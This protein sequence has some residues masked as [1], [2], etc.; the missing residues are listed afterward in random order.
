MVESMDLPKGFTVETN[1]PVYED[2]HQ[3][4]ELD[5]LILGT[6]GTVT[7][8]TLY[9]CRDRPSEGRQGVSWIEQ[10]VGRRGRLKVNAIVAVSTTGFAPAAE[11]FASES[12]IPLRNVEDVTADDILRGIPLTAPVVYREASFFDVKVVMIPEDQTMEEIK[13]KG[14]EHERIQLKND[15]KVIQN[16]DTGE[17]YSILSLW[18][19]LQGVYQAEIYG[20]VNKVG[21]SL[22]KVIEVDESVLFPLRIEMRG[23]RCKIAQLVY[24]ATVKMYMSDAPLAYC[25]SYD[26]R[27]VIAHWEKGEGEDNFTVIL[28]KKTL[29]SG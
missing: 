27:H 5:I 10:L 29:E 22:E 13:S 21:D 14:I 11:K 8:K 17:Q 9:E 23:Q 20:G 25:V 28:T 4:A 18:Q 16:I 15:E 2:G 7:Y 26:D 1:K 6:I 24:T 19:R 3:I 12:N